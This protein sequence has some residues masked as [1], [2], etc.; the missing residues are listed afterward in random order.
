MVSRYYAVK[1]LLESGI[2]TL[3][4]TVEQLEA[5]LISK[6]FKIINYDISHKEH[7][8]ILKT[9]GILSIAER[10]KALTYIGNGE[11]IVF[12]KISVSANEKRLLLAHELGHIA[13]GHITDNAVLGYRPCG[14]IDESQEDEANAFALEFLA[15]VGILKRKHINTPEKVS[16]MTLLD[17]KLSRL[18]ADEV[19]NY[20]KFIEIEPTLYCQFQNPKKPFNTKT[21]AIRTMIILF[22]AVALSALCATVKYIN[23]SK[24]TDITTQTLN[25]N[26][27]AAD[28]VYITHSGE[29]YH[30]ADCMYVRNKKNIIE[31]TIDNAINSNYEPCS[32][33]QP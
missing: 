30:R 9:A 13:L 24:A 16:A 18:I 6:G 11:K 2:R 26:S 12:V 28:M 14:L 32:V 15:P 31:I 7:A 1:E 5:V 10:T 27:A 22:I 4:I 21:V 33:C 17:D 20:K 23:V 19:H 25:D 3:P 8:E 29:K